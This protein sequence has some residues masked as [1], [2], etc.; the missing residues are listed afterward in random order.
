MDNKDFD[1]WCDQWQAAVDKGIFPEKK[2]E[3]NENVGS[4]FGFMNKELV[5]KPI[6]DC[7]TKYWNDVHDL[8]RLYGQDPEILCEYLRNRLH[9]EN[10]V[11]LKSLAKD[12]ADSPNP[13]RPTTVGMD[14]DI[15]NP[16]ST[17]QTYSV[18]DLKSLDDLKTKLHDLLVKLNSNEGSGNSGSAKLETQIKNLQKQIDEF[19]DSLSKT[20]VPGQI[21]S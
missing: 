18:D 15:T 21:G 9:E 6:T 14:Q 20:G 13:V 19:S 8:S 3:D 4:Y 11:D 16:V 17:G 10:D 12:V 1:K 7:D 2:P 5:K